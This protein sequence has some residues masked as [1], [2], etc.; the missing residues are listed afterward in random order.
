[1]KNEKRK[2]KNLTPKG[3]IYVTGGYQRSSARSEDDFDSPAES[4]QENGGRRFF[5]CTDSNKVNLSHPRPQKLQSNTIC[6]KFPNV[7]T[8]L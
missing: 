8:F 6:S 1:M 5:N 4:H 2:G 7:C 3:A